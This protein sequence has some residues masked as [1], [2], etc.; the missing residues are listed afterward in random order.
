MNL[1]GQKIGRLRVIAKARR[2]GYVVCLCDCGNV[3]EV[4]SVS[5]TKRK[6]TISCGCYRKEVVSITG[7]NNIHRNSERRNKLNEKY[8]TNVGLILSTK[9]S[10][11]NK[12]GYRGVWFD[13]VHNT[14]Q[15]YIY[16]RHKKYYLGT[17]KNVEEAAK[18]R[19][20]A[21]DIFFAPVIESVKAEL[22]VL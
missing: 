19:K 3:H 2:R 9:L 10:R 13:Q 8:G 20:E 22:S 17:F 12:S 18:A 5:L 15:S 6:P 21:E 1:V 14:Y 16:F 11:S 4:L 7:R